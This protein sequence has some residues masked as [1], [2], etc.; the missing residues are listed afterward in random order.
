[1]V[2]VFQGMIYYY[3]LFW[4]VIYIDKS[5][6]KTLINKSVEWIGTSMFSFCCCGTVS[7]T[8][9]W[10]QEASKKHELVV[11]RYDGQIGNLQD[12]GGVWIPLTYDLSFGSWMACC[13]R[14]RSGKRRKFTLTWGPRLEGNLKKM[15]FSKIILARWKKWFLGVCF[16]CRVEISH[17]GNKNASHMTSQQGVSTNT[18]GSCTKD[19]RGI[20]GFVA[21]N[22]S[23]S[24]AGNAFAIGWTFWSSL[25]V[26]GVFCC[27]IMVKLLEL[28]I[29]KYGK[30]MFR[31][32][33]CYLAAWNSFSDV[34]Y[35]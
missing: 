25:V 1:M 7:L 17:N 20:M 21:I 16:P 15:I 27:W 32:Q 29:T 12:W 6:I 22:S 18:F 33:K 24:T 2:F 26:W 11:W 10:K 19:L 9:C 31:F 14:V 3:T 28:R 34:M 5:I 4:M 35:V 23:F 8:F 30:N 13:A